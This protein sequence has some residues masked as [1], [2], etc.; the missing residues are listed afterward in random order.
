M[1]GA[2][3]AAGAAGLGL[4]A[5]QGVKAVGN[6]PTPQWMQ[7]FNNTVRQAFDAGFDKMSRAL[8]SKEVNV[9]T[10]KDLTITRQPTRGATQ[11]PK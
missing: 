6:A 8:G 2:L 9:K 4:A 7:G 3:P 5:A 10:A 1:A 11:G